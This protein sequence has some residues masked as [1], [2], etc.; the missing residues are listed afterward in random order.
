MVTELLTVRDDGAVRILTM[1]RSNKL[2]ALNTELTTGLVDALCDADSDQGVRTVLL[3]GAGRGFCAGAD[4][5]EFDGFTEAD[6]DAV[7]QRAE[8]TW[9]LQS[10]LPNLK[11]PVIAAARGPAVGGGAGLLV[12]SDLAVV[13]ETLKFGYP[14]LKHD[15]VAALVMTGLTRAMGRKTA[16]ELL[17]LRRLIT[18]EEALAA[19]V[20]NRVVADSDLMSVALDMAHSVAEVHPIAMQTTKELFYRTAELP[21][22]EAM[23]AGRDVNQIMRGF[24]T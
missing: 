2:N 18:A 10:L 11:K 8:L 14:E 5:S 23:R 4:L 13:S 12:G 3:T 9:R 17:A 19:G 24:R 7:R 20:V 16:F 1:N 21:Y 15:I 22:D 6:S